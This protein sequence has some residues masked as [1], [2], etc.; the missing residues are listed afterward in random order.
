MKEP[1]GYQKPPKNQEKA[2]TV[3]L[4]LDWVYGYRSRDVKNNIGMLSDGSIVYNAAAVGI[5]YDPSDHLQRHF[6]RHTDDILSIAFS[7]DKKLVATGELGPKPSIHIWDGLTMTLVHTLKGKLLKGIEALAFSPSGKYIAAVARDND[8]T[9]A[10]YDATNGAFVGMDKG[11]GNHIVDVAFKNEKEFATVGVKHFKHW[12]VKSGSLPSSKGLFGKN[13]N[14]LG[15]V[16][17]A[18]DNALTGSAKGE[19]YVWAGNKIKQTLKTHK[20]PVDAIHATE[21]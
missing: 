4:D 1:R 16:A 20:R 7:P 9:V 10:V 21:K 5:V 13:D 3:E 6:I 15:C 14:K 17:F 2:P 11:D 18:G 12:T 8:H 19:V